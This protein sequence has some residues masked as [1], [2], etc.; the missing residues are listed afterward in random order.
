MT[1]IKPFCALRPTA[2]CAPFIAALPY[3]V[4]ST[5]EA[6]AIVKDNPQ[7]F[8]A[9]DEP[10]VNFPEGTDAYD[11]PVYLKAGELLGQ[12]KATGHME[13]DAAPSYYLYELTKD[14][15]VQ[16]GFVGCVAI[17]DYLNGIVKE[18]ESTRV[19]KEMDR[20]NHIRGCEAQTGP[21]FL[22]Y[23]F[24]E[25]LASLLPAIKDTDP[26]F[27]FVANDGVRHRGFLLPASMNETIT[28]RFSELGRVYI[29][30]GHHRVAAASE[31][32]KARRVARGSNDPTEESDYFLAVLFADAE[33]QILPYYRVV[34]DLNGLTS[35]EFLEEL[36]S[37]FTVEPILDMKTRMPL[38][39]HNASDPAER[40]HA[41]DSITPLEKG[42]FSVLLE[43]T[44]YSCTIHPE[45]RSL[46]PYENLDVSILQRQLLEP[47]L[48]IA[49]PRRSP[50]I[51]FIG[52]IRGLEELERRCSTDCAC[53]FALYPTDIQ[54]LFAV[55]DAGLLMPPKSTWFEPKLRS[56]LFIHEI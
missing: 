15:H 7:S 8:L 10:V 28:K 9:I 55:A 41:I 53:A 19:D 42:S 27:D 4:Q 34:H 36:G 25:T 48:G 5:S 20:V 47:V 26:L 43:D 45:D 40:Q 18:H 23:H 33:L 30:D 52:G 13:I 6:R 21:I 11:L 37:R 14:D 49:D 29:A 32:A 12:L 24:D 16:N 22:T 56:G 46:D 35:N 54:E 50:R 1:T 38:T 51:D 17:D 44:W 3:D 39:L 31:V 2:E